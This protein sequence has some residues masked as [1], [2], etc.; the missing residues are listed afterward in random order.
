MEALLEVSFPVTHLLLTRTKQWK[1]ILD[2]CGFWHLWPSCLKRGEIRALPVDRCL[3]DHYPLKRTNIHCMQYADFEQ[4]YDQFKHKIYTYL[5]YRS[6]KNKELAEDLTSEVFMK[7]LEK[8]HTYRKDSSFQSW[9]YAI[10]H[11]HLIDYFR[12]NKPIVDMEDVKNILHG[13]TDSRSVLTKRIASEQVSH[14]VMFLTDTERD[15]VLLRY[16]QQLPMKAI[17]EITDKGEA[18]VRVIL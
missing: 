5:Y 18:T 13:D 17:S 14:L 16:Q 7:A 1:S 8:F 4:H 10:A 11:N 9:I 3:F 6:G 12:K 2:Y 15:V